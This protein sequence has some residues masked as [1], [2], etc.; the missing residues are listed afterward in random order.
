MRISNW[1][2]FYLG[3][4]VCVLL[5]TVVTTR[6]SIWKGRLVL[7]LALALTLPALTGC[8]ASARHLGPVFVGIAP[9]LSRGHVHAG[10]MGR[11]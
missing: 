3:V 4:S 8:M 9:T 1:Q 6:T 2:A 5:F 10:H 11:R 7:L